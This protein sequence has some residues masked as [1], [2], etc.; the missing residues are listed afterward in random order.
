MFFGGPKKYRGIYKYD[1]GGGEWTNITVDEIREGGGQPTSQIWLRNIWTIPD[2]HSPLS[3]FLSEG[4][5]WVGS[6]L[7]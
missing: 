2:S 1:K 3:S 6:L 4:V 7:I 5:S